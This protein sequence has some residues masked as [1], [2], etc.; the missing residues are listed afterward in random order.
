[1]IQDRVIREFHDELERS[2]QPG[3]V[4]RYDDADLD[5][6]PARHSR[7]PRSHPTTNYPRPGNE[8]ASKVQ[9]AESSPRPP[10]KPAAAPQTAHSKL[11]ENKPAAKQPAESSAPPQQSQP[12]G[13]GEGIF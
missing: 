12:D 6:I 13:F 9:T 5:F 2:K 1:M 10:H 7:G 11:P 4:S 3:Y 8:R